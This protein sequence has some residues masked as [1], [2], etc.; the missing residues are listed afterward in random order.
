VKRRKMKD[1]VRKI[2]ARG[3]K[4]KIGEVKENGNDI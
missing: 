1:N 2:K 4:K 3:D